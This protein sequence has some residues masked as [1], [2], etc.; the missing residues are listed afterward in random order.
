[1]VVLLGNR[2]EVFAGGRAAEEEIA[3][4]AAEKVVAAIAVEEVVTITGDEVAIV[5][6]GGGRRSE[7]LELRVAGGSVLALDGREKMKRRREMV[8]KE[9]GRR[10]GESGHMEEERR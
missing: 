2:E 4:A 6:E 9:E 7:K 10:R 8:E 3:G 5:S 1:L